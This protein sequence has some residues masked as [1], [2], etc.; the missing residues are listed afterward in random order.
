[1]KLYV[2]ESGH[3]AV[4][5]LHPLTISALAR[6]EVP[7]A[8]WRKHRAG[9]LDPAS[10]GVL[11][12]AFA[13]DFHGEAETFGRFPI[14]AIS[15]DVLVDAATLAASGGL[16]AYDA[17]QLASALAARVADPGCTGFACFDRDLRRAAAATGFELVPA[18]VT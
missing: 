5:R 9:E 10:A 15:L 13:A 14:V 7:A 8:F 1:M 12:R 16:R 11:T 4:R 6:V 18:P 3:A 2:D 17:V